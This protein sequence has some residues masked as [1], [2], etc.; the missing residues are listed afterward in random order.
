MPPKRGL[1][2]A[3]ATTL[4]LLLLAGIDMASNAR[5]VGWSEAALALAGLAPVLAFALVAFASRSRLA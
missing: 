5:P 3:L 4:G 2:P 1:G